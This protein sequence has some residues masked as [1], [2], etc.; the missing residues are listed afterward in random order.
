MPAIPRKELSSALLRA[1]EDSGVSAHLLSSPTANPRSVHV[2]LAGEDAMSVQAYVWTLTRGG[3]RALPDEYRIQMTGVVSPLEMNPSGPTLLLGYEPSLG[4]FAGFDVQN[5]RSFTPGSP[6]IQIPIAVLRHAITE[7]LTFETKS[8][9]DVVCGIRP[10]HM[11]AY[12][13]TGMEIH[14]FARP[15]R[16]CRTMQE[17]VR[18][19]GVSEEQMQKLSRP[20]VKVAA[21]VA[22][23]T[24]NGA[25]RQ[26]V[27]QAY[28]NRCAVTGLQ[29]KLVDAAHIL[30]VGTPNSTDEVTNGIALTPTIHRAYD[31]G[32]VFVD[33]Q[34]KIR[35]CS[36]KL[37]QLRSVRLDGGIDEL[38]KYHG[39]RIIL[40]TNPSLRPAVEYI[41]AANE[42]RE[43]S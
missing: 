22:R 14:E 2:G 8:N 32:L 35:I 23:W 38:R 27:L 18:G 40:P 1:F 15:S 21:E 11:L 19:A 6:S 5:H 7:G 26:L 42:L 39:Q 28:D 34:F 9:R 25:F 16:A 20:R 43:V 37:D 33:D 41:R 17:V 4:V 36:T 3:R 10:D 31:R 12:A 24:R 13:T 30:P 29:L